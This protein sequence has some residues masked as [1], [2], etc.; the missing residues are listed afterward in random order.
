MTLAGGTPAFTYLWSNGET[1][2]DIS[3]LAIGNYFVTVSDGNGCLAFD[4]ATLINIPGPTLS[5]SAD[6]STCGNA[7]GAIDVITSGGTAPY[8]YAWSNGS[9]DEDLIA[10]AAGTYSVTIIDANSCTTVESQTI[11]NNQ[12]NYLINQLIN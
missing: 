11:N 4:N 7:N 1:T 12:I 9:T 2:Q 3:S 10:T 6:S 5:S 8:N